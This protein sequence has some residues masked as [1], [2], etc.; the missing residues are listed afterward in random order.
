[1]RHFEWIRV[2][3]FR[4]FQDVELKLKPLNVLIGA[5]GSGK[6][7]LLDVFSLLAASASGDLN[8]TISDISGVE[9][10]SD[11]LFSGS[12]ARAVPWSPAS[13]CRIP[14]ASRR[15]S[16][17]NLAAG[18]E[19]RDRRRDAY[20][21]ANAESTAIQISRSYSW[22]RAVFRAKG[23]AGKGG[24]VRPRWEYNPT[25]SALS[26]VPKMFRM[27]EDFRKRLAFSTHYHVLDVGPRAPIRLPQQMRD[28]NAAGHDGED[29]VS[30]LYTLRETD[31]DRF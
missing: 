31:P 19:L 18:R 21:A 5:N 20:P 6:T 12:R 30:C 8:K 17:R 2:Q 11:D 7:S 9:S 25:E 29:L 13:P 24:L 16:H 15:V 4:R 10:E 23:K 1:M 26:Q 22:Q 3:G 27:P 28:A 14:A